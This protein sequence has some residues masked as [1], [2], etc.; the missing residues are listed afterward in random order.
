[1]FSAGSGKGSNP[2]PRGLKRRPLRDSLDTEFFYISTF[3]YFVAVIRRGFGFFNAG[4]NP[5]YVATFRHQG[6]G[7]VR[8]FLDIEAHDSSPLFGTTQVYTPTL[9]TS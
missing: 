1:M 9:N 3:R 7:I 8:P 4:E 6:R 5:N 2:V